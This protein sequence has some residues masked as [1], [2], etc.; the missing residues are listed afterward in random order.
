MKVI[1][2]K[3]KR[4]Y[5][6][7]TQYNMGNNARKSLP[8]LWQKEEREIFDK[9]L[10]TKRSRQT[11]EENERAHR[12]RLQ[13]STRKQRGATTTSMLPDTQHHTATTTAIQTSSS[14]SSSKWSSSLN[15][16][17]TVFNAT[18][19]LN[20]TSS[21]S[22]KP[23][24]DDSDIEEDQLSDTQVSYTPNQTSLAI[25]FRLF[26][27]W[28]TLSCSLMASLSEVKRLL[29]K[30]AQSKDVPLKKTPNDFIFRVDHD[31]FLEDEAE[32]LYLCIHSSAYPQQ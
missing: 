12:A 30:E 14:S 27:Q 11:K 21:S 19:T 5:G 6:R 32:L 7:D 22:I 29:W 24:D 15:L 28:I 2:L 18:D 4:T 3:G 16:S 9:L 1:K 31:D 20:A 17:K 26:K 10:T 8:L 13:V 25:K 23:Q